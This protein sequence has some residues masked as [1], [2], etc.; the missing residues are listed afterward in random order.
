[1][2]SVSSGWRAMNSCTAAALS[3][4]FQQISAKKADKFVTFRGIFQ[5]MAA[6]WPILAPVWSRIGKIIEWDK[7]GVQLF[8]GSRR[9]AN[10]M[11]VGGGHIYSKKWMINMKSEAE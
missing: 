2:T 10:L 9:I 11:D 6:N 3:P 8:A 1:M 7:T 4:V 5:K